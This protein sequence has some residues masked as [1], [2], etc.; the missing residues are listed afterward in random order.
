M[1]KTLLM[2]HGVGCGGEAWDVMRP[3]FEAAGWNCI[4]PTLFAGKR[5]RDNPPADLPNL[6][7]ADY[8]NAAADMARDIAA[9]TGQKPAIIGHSMGGL[10]AQVLTERGLVSKA[11]FLTPAQPEG[12]SVTDIRVLRTFWSVL[13]NGTK[14]AETMSH[15]V[16]PKGFSYGV[17]NAV[18]KARHREIYASALYDI[19]GV[20]A[21]LLHP[22]TIDASKITVPTLTICAAK[23]RATVPKAVRKVAAKYAAAPVAGDYLEYADHA[24]WIVDEPGTDRVT[25]DIVAWLKTHE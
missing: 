4:A 22:P 12:C 1:T 7:L 2:I 13:K 8:I 17:L 23:D 16:G 6:R 18:P 19:G 11:V 24:H 25:A 3:G 9:K 21:D 15:K 10:I 20:Y 14:K 5:L